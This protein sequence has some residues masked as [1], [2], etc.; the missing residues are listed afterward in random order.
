MRL[1]LLDSLGSRPAPLDTG[2]RSIGAVKVLRNS[3]TDR[4]NFRC[5]YCM[6]EEGVR[7][8]PKEGILT[9]EE[10]AEIVRAAVEVHGIRRF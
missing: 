8:L 7:W 2:P 1:T 3:V 9:F 10:I 6:P 4:F 5:V